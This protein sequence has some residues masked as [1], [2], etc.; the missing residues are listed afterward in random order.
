MNLNW[1]HMLKH[2]ATYLLLFAPITSGIPHYKL[3][4]NY[5]SEPIW[6]PLD[7]QTHQAEHEVTCKQPLNS[8]SMS[9]TAFGLSLDN[10]HTCS[11]RLGPAFGAVH[12]VKSPGPTSIWWLIF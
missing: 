12:D 1:L 6:E 3:F 9:D 2:V 7:S 10:V 8:A 5:S 4:L 11:A